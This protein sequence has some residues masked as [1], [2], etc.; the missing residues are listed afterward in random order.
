MFLVVWFY[1]VIKRLFC[2][3]F[4]PPFSKNYENK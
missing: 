1:S 4:C 2:P 3:P